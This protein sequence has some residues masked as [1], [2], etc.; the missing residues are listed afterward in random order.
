MSSGNS[1]IDPSWTLFLDRDGVINKRIIEGYVRSWE[2]FEFM[3]GVQEALK[4]LSN[5]FLKVIVVSNQQGIGKGIMTEREVIAV[6]EMMTKA[7]KDNGGRIDRVYFSPSLKE[8]NSLYRKPNIG[9][10]LS[11]RKDFPGI[12]FKKSVMVGDSE[13]DMIFGRK[14]KMRT[15]LISTDKEEIKNIAEL[16]DFV[17]P[18]LLS[19][20]KNVEVI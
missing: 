3:P 6:H 4:I 1:K 2:Q 11:A 12:D 16:I 19:F 18:D 7:I 20:A 15:V 10:A 14:L 9:M 13:S 17:Y 5:I 8:E